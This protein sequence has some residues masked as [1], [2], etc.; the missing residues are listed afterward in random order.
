MTTLTKFE[1]FLELTTPFFCTH[2]QTN[3]PKFLLEAILIINNST[4][5]NTQSGYYA[6][7]ATFPGLFY[8]NKLDFLRKVFFFISR[9]IENSIFFTNIQF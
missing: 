6:K 7:S 2:S 4:Q 1:N 3:F 8:E 5:K 9:N